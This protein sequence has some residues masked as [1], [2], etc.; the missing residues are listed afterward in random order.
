MPA[1]SKTNMQSKASQ[2]AFPRSGRPNTPPNSPTAQL[3][4]PFEF[5]KQ[6]LDALKVVQTHEAK[7][8]APVAGPQ[9]EPNPQTSEPAARASK[10]EVKDVHEV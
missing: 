10:L 5:A 3:A 8:I 2:A 4:N 7:K 6:F 9:V 1:H